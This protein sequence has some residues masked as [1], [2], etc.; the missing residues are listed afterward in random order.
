MADYYPLLVRA[1]SSLPQNSAEARRAVFDRAR[2]ALLKQL[3]SVSPPLPEGE[4]TRERLS[5]EEAIRRIEADF[6]AQDNE[7]PDEELDADAASDESGGEPA[8]SG[9]AVSGEKADVPS[10]G[11]DVPANLRQADDE[12]AA[13]P[14]DAVDHAPPDGASGENAPKGGAVGVN[15]AGPLPRGQVRSRDAAR[16]AGL[17]P[18]LNRTEKPAPSWK[19]PALWAL[20]IVV[21]LIV[22]GLVVVNSSAVL[23]REPQTAEAPATPEAQPDRPKD[24]DRMAAA[25]D[26]NARRAPDSARQQA[27]GTQRA[28]LLEESPGGNTPP[29][30]FE[31]TV[32]WKTETFEAGPGLPPELGVRGVVTIP[33]RQISMEFV[34]RRNTDQTLP[35]SHTIELAFGLP[36]DFAFGSIASIPGIRMKPTQQAQGVPLAGLSVRVNPTLFLV[37]LSTVPA[38]RQR[39]VTLMQLYPWIDVPFVYENNKRAVILF[40]KGDMGEQA[41][42]EAFASWGEL[43]ERTPEPPPAQQ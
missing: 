28:V 1:I 21:G 19:K 22:L 36:K 6:A 37:G 5:L 43:V 20:L 2:A 30:S 15:A 17:R 8:S 33:E 41:F 9:E 10:S 25:G 23:E 4:I 24:A 38:E 40:D 13:S 18:G 29:Q 31:G 3:R 39:N 12:P 26:A 34:L 35:A 32:T 11:H 42:H 16:E 14:E 27:A 7:N